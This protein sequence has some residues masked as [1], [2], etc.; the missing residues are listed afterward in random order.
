[1]SQDQNEAINNGPPKRFLKKGEGL[2]RFAAYKP[3]PPTTAKKVDGRQTFVRFRLENNKSNVKREPPLHFIPPEILY[4]D[5]INLST[6]IPKIA[7][8][9]II[10]TPV[11]PN[12]QR[13]YSTSPDVTCSPELNFS[14]CVSQASDLCTPVP[15]STILAL[16]QQI[17]QIESTVNELREKLNNCQCGAVAPKPATRRRP[18][19]RAASRA[20]K[21]QPGDTDNKPN[22][23]SVDADKEN[24]IRKVL[25]NL[26]DDV[27]QL[28]ARF[29][30]INLRE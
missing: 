10:H 26:T 16:S 13:S 15:G 14:R 3:P 23:Q 9:K 12:R 4:D 24:S 19:T 7:P 2:K 11:R 5:S 1:M 18:T 17:Q 30:D 8:P 28:R 29:Q 27:A 22:G 20:A 21:S 6:E 25:N